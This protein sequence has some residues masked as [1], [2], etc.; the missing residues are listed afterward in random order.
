MA[1]AKD[2]VILYQAT[3]EFDQRE[4]KANIDELS[5]RICRPRRSC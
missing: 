3:V 1:S 2:L 5:R 4:A